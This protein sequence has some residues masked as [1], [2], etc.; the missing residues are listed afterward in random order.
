MKTT[1]YHF[2]I[3]L[4]L[5]CFSSV[6]MAQTR[7]IDLSGEWK[8]KLDPSNIGIKKMWYNQDF[9]SNIT[10]PGALQNQGYGNNVTAKT[11]WVVA[12]IA[13]NSWYTEPMFAKY[14][15]DDNLHYTNNF[16]PKKHYIG[17]AWYQLKFKAPA[18]I[19]SK[20]IVLMLERV[21]WESQLYINGKYVNTERSLLAP[22][23]FD[24]SKFL[25]PGEDNRIVLRVNN[26]Q[27]ISV[28][29]NAHS[30]GDQTM[31][32]WNGII[33]DIMLE[34]APE[35]VRIESC[36]IYPDIDKKSA[37]IKL[38]I[39]NGEEK[40]SILK[41]DFNVESYNTTDPI[42]K[43][44][45][46]FNKS[47]AHGKHEV[48]FIIN[49]GDRM[50]LWDEYNPTL[51]NIK[52][53]VKN[54]TGYDTHIDNFGM[55]KIEIKDDKFYVNGVKRFF[56]GNLMCG[57]FPLTGHPSMDVD[58]WV[59]I[60]TKNK[61]LGINHIRFHSW[62]PP[63]AAFI[64]ADRVG[65]YVLAETSMWARISSSEQLSFLQDEGRNSLN[66]Y[67]NH[68]SF[69][70]MMM[71]NELSSSTAIVNTLLTEWKKDDR[72]VYSSLASSVPSL[73][74]ECEFF[75]SG[76]YRSNKGWPPRPQSSFFF[77]HKPSSNFEFYST[78]KPFKVPTLVHEVGQHCSYPSLDQES[79]YIG[80][81]SAGYLH[82][83]K[84]QLEER[85]LYD[86]WPDY[87]Q[88][89]GALQMI[90]YKNEIEAYHRAKNLP[91]YQILQ[92]E[93]FPGQGS[94]LVGV[95]DY[96]YDMKPYTS[97]KK[98][99]SFN[100]DCV[101]L[102]EMEKFVWTNNEVFY[103]KGLITNWT[104]SDLN[105]ISIEYK[106]TDMAGNTLKEELYTINAI[107]GGA[108]P[109][110]NIQFPLNGILKATKLKL[111]ANIVGQEMTNE[112]DFWVYPKKVE[113][114]PELDKMITTKWD[115]T[116]ISRLKNGETVILQLKDDQI[117]GELPY[118]FLT[119]Y[120]TQFQKNGNSQ[121]M[122]LICDPKHP[123]FN[124]FPTDSHT[125]WQWWELLRSAK[126]LV[127]D[128]FDMKDH[129]DKDF[130]PLL[131]LIDGWKTNRKVGVMA[132]AKYGKGKLI[133][134]A[135]DLQNGLDTCAVKRQMRH[136]LWNYINSDNF[137]PSTKV[138]KKQ[139]DALLNLNQKS[140]TK[141]KI[142]KSIISSIITTS[143][144]SN[145]PISNMVDG[146]IH[147]IWHTDYSSNSAKL[148]VNIIIELN[149]VE[150]VGGIVYT[151]RQ[152]NQSGRIK[153]IQVYISEDGKSWESPIIKESLPNTSAKQEL[154]LLYFH[155]AKY[156]KLEVLS[157]WNTPH[158]AIAELEFLT[159]D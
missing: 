127:F 96:F 55:R 129:W 134:S 86:M 48:T 94:A 122:G 95:M 47:I 128:Q 60:L 56:R 141:A 77:K 59:D 70:M 23:R 4:L 152:D 92:L 124:D 110:G 67:G 146:D 3:T 107:R 125:N 123:L 158:V 155:K 62:M 113:H 76:H 16:Q 133:I 119:V 88:A 15:E 90:L 5:F 84:E 68:P 46:K 85:G 142:K 32:A 11:P 135:I 61:K 83:A 35:S 53:G 151:P 75:I 28:G 87:V 137:K 132:E 74:D 98:F 1:L 154:D 42:H 40:T 64:A 116:S 82:I 111:T 63:K 140:S 6:S 159:N 97:E 57:S 72:R 126:P 52:I 138:S 102:S 112:W 43:F 157:S 136:S 22:H 66:E 101:L 149:K 91:G 27:I 19:K 80:S 71:G 33:G 38:N 36:D 106:I 150:S 79:K 34:I 58:S 143:T 69:M 12:E 26:D 17:A 120:W 156:I 37:I 20:K 105:N 108:Q 109:F 81:Q 7:T 118:S 144:S 100:G 13:D 44:S 9:E 78:V 45:K 139:V 103:S 25:I 18:D 29:K 89:S 51:Y 104:K 2:T 8:F 21:H 114:H 93:D 31:S 14:R 73:T 115:E 121:T 145:Y 99:N 10:L 30:W 39:Y 50:V 153:E 147:K 65:I 117:K 24:I 130:R 41:F 148:P 131:Q 54:S 49:M